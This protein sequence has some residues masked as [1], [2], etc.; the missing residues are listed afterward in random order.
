MRKT[1]TQK[2]VDSMVNQCKSAM[3]LAERD[4]LRSALFFEKHKLRKCLKV[5]RWYSRQPNGEKAKDILKDL[6]GRKIEP[7][8]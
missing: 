7:I 5:I 4:V 1:K 2:L 8:K 6:K 3:E